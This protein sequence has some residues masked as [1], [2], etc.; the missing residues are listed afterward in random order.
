MIMM[1]A[2]D[3][4]CNSSVKSVLHGDAPISSQ[5]EHVHRCRSEKFDQKLRTISRVAQE[6]CD[7]LLKGVPPGTF[8]GTCGIWGPLQDH[9]FRGPRL[10]SSGVEVWGLTSS[11]IGGWLV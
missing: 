2:L 1:L 5:H 11:D 3:V 10:S 9:S 7:R 6:M 8:V 4:R